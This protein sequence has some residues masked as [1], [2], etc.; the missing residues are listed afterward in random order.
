MHTIRVTAA[1]PFVAPATFREWRERLRSHGVLPV[2]AVAGSR[3]KTTVVR[4]LDAIYRSAG[5]RTATW[6]NL[7]VE[8]NGRRQ[9]GELHPWTRALTRLTEGAVDIAVQELDWATVHAVGLPEAIYPVVVV[10]NVCVNN[11]ACLAQPE[12]QRALRAMPSILAAARRDGTLVLSG[13]D[14]AAGGAEVERAVPTILVAPSADAPLVRAHLDRGGTAA[15]LSAD[16][17]RVGTNTRAVSLGTSADM[18]FALHGAAGFQI[19]NGLVAAAVAH[20]CGLPVTTA[21]E[22]LREFSAPA[23]MLGSFNVVR[24]GEAVA[25]VDRASPPWFLRPSLRSVAHL[26]RGRL[27]T[28]IGRSAAVAP[29]DL[30]EVGR[31]LGRASDALIMHSEAVEPDRAAAFRRGVALND[32]PPIVIHVPT[33]RQAINRALKTVRRTDVI[34]ILADDALSVLRTLERARAAS[35]A[36]QRTA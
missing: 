5:L 18:S 34:F 35:P 13:E 7:G 14:Y 21:S 6:T 10:T 16:D 12:T 32:V 36:V 3:G 9:H 26:P 8:I 11:E 15:W 17:L 24:L 30:P 1:P 4:L 22:I 20:A 33:E 31:L 19:Q 27:V 23:L 28:V 2:V 29:H 25:I